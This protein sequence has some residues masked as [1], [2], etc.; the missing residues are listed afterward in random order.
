LWRPGL[1]GLGTGRDKHSLQTGN[2]D[3]D[4]LFMTNM[5]GSL[6]EPHAD[7]RL[8]RLKCKFIYMPT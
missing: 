1:P 3:N 7:D 8:C 6:R 4:A 5:Y 2:D